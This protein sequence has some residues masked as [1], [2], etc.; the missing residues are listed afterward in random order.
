MAQLSRGVFLR[1]RARVYE[2]DRGRLSARY[3]AAQP[4][5]KREP[6]KIVYVYIHIHVLHIFVARSANIIYECLYVRGLKREDSMNIWQ[7][8]GEG[9]GRDDSM[10][11]VVRDTNT[12]GKK[13]LELALPS[14]RMLRINASPPRHFVRWKGEDET[15]GDLKIEIRGKS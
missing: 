11:V 15:K 7:I 13:T 3:F 8:S 14:P 5:N 6:P 2:H 12:F 4:G 10:Y 9:R 1:S